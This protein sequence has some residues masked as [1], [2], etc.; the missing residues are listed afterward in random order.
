MLYSGSLN[1]FFRKICFDSLR[2]F[3]ICYHHP[4]TLAILFKHLKTM[5]RDNVTQCQD[6]RIYRTWQQQWQ[7][8][9]SK[10]LMTSNRKLTTC[11]NVISSLSKRETQFLSLV[12]PINVIKTINVIPTINV[13]KI[14]H[15]CNTNHKCYNF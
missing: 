15:K 2:P 3:I 9:Y 8:T 11:A 13:I 1:F 6:S 7:C 12:S 14:D 4:Q 5:S 10:I